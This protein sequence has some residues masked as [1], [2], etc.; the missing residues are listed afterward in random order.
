MLR[1]APASCRFIE[2]VNKLEWIL[3]LCGISS[4]A[5]LVLGAFVMVF[6][7]KTRGFRL[8]LEILNTVSTRK[9]I[10]EEDF[11]AQAHGNREPLAVPRAG[12]D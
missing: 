5:F 6:F 8:N 3:Y 7:Y 4:G 2:R 9:K 11:Y 12:D 1:A 10:V